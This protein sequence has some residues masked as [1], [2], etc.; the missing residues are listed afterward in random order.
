MLRGGGSDQNLTGIFLSQ[1]EIGQGK[2]EITFE[3]NN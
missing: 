2:S 1:I 3:N